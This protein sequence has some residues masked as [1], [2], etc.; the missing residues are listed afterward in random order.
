MRLRLISRNLSEAAA[1]MEFAAP[2]SHVYNPLYYASESHELY[3][4]LFGEG[5]KEVIFVGMNPG[6]WGMAQ[7]GVPFGDVTMVRD[8][9]GIEAPVGKPANEHPKRPIDGFGCP[10]SEV[11][12]TRFWGWARD[13]FGTPEVFF[14]RFFVWNYCPLS[15]MLESGANFTPDKLPTAERAPLFEVCDAALCEIAGE[16]RPEWVIGVGKFAEKR[17]RAALGHTPVKV[18]GILHP[19]PASPAANSDWAGQAQKQ[20]SSLGIVL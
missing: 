17:A 7:T 13:T 4:T 15:F 11:S 1:S 12:G 5:R 14:S 2:I 20:L 19:S 9:M 8:W 16:L 18:A 10:R 6:P 3:L